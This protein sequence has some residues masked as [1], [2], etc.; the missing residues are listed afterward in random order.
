MS[1]QH[2]MQNHEPMFMKAKF[3]VRKLVGNLE[4]LQPMRCIYL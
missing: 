1:W 4:P 2:V 3:K